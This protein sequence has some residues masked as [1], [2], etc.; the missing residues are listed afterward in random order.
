MRTGPVPLQKKP[1]VLIIRFPGRCLNEVPNG[2]DMQ[3][4]EC[5]MTLGGPE[6]AFDL[7]FRRIEIVSSDGI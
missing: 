5:P 3:S 1:V 4:R 7:P 6:E 2:N